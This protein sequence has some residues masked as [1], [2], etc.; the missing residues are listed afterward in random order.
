MWITIISTKTY[1]KKS[2]KSFFSRIT[3]YS[4]ILRI[5]IAYLLTAN[6]LARGLRQ[7]PL[8]QAKLKLV[9]F[10][11][12]LIFRVT[13]HTRTFQHFPEEWSGLLWAPW[14]Y[15]CASRLL[16]H[17]MS[18]VDKTGEGTRYQIE[19]KMKELR[20]FSLKQGDMEDIIPGFRSLEGCFGGRKSE[21]WVFDKVP[22][23]GHIKLMVML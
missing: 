9:C 3:P 7:S 18:E 16:D 2:C 19:R 8:A 21:S 22:S 15:Q 17:F 5:I 6:G 11:M 13:D 10:L 14:H 4:I 23:A 12:F 1:I 20:L